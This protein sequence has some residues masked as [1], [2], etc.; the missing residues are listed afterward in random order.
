[1]AEL[2]TI[3][4]SSI[5]GYTDYLADD[6]TLDT[7]LFRGQSND[8]PLIPRIGRIQVDRPLLDAEKAIL[9]MF[10]QQSLPY[11]DRMP[12]NEWEWLAVAQHHGLPTRLLDWT[13]NPLI[14][15]WFAVERQPSGQQNGVVWVFK[16]S[17][18]DFVNV[19]RDVPFSEGRTKV[20]RP[21]HIT[22]RIRVQAGYFTVHKYMKLQRRFVPLETMRAYKSRL[23]KLFVPSSAFADLRYRLDQYG[24]NKSTVFPG[25]DGLSGH[26]EWLHSVLG[27]EMH[28][29]RDVATASWRLSNS[30]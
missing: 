21:S 29:R 1:M 14:A 30:P 4:L 23:V 20:F 27:D 24:V 5:R 28:L 6:N 2:Q 16:P 3:Q 18:S 17:A 12:T 13:L 11:L 19:I 8:S 22:E 15:L 9:D 26:I 25:L 10:K 7:V